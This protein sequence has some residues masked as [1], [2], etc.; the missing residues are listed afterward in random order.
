[1]VGIDTIRQKNRATNENFLGC[2]GKL[3]KSRKIC[4][5]DEV[6]KWV[7]DFV[8]CGGWTPQGT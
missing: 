2:V 4:Y 3:A 8:L 1:L 7:M 6:I 5:T